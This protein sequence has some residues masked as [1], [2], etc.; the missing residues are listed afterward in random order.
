MLISSMIFHV[1]FLTL[2]T[3]TLLYGVAIFIEQI[4][5]ISN[6]AGKIENKLSQGLSFQHATYALSRTPIPI[7]LVILSY[8]IET[9]ISSRDFVLICFIMC[10]FAT[11]GLLLSLRCINPVIF[12]IKR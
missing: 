12:F 5:L 1:E 2:S 3:L 7:I 8:L 9:N 10:L 11:L 6:I 4:A